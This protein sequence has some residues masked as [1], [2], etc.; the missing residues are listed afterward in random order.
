MYGVCEAGI[1][2]TICKLYAGSVAQDPERY[3]PVLLIL[4]AD[5]CSLITSWELR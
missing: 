1:C 5:K 3:P 2:Q 4:Y